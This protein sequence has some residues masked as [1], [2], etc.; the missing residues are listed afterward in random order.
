MAFPLPTTPATVIPRTSSMPKIWM[1]LGDRYRSCEDLRTHG[2]RPGR[3][4]RRVKA[5]PSRWPGFV[6]AECESAA[7]GARPRQQRKVGKARRRRICNL[8]PARRSRN[9]LSVV[10]AG[11]SRACSRGR[12]SCLTRYGHRGGECP[13]GRLAWP[14]E[15]RERFKSAILRGQAVSPAVWPDPGSDA[16]SLARPIG[17]TRLLRGTDAT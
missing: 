2:Y 5:R 16:I 15:G 11:G 17:A 3:D 6:H 1:T 7:G 14:G 9:L 12:Q 10:L 4:E 8:E 13:S